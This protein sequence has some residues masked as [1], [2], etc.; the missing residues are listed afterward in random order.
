MNWFKC[1]NDGNILINMHNILKILQNT[2]I[3][4]IK[5]NQVDILSAIQDVINKSSN[6]STNISQEQLNQILSA[7]QA[8]PSDTILNNQNNIISGLDTTKSDT[9]NAKS[10]L[11]NI[12]DTFEYAVSG[13]LTAGETSIT[14]KDD[15]IKEDTDLTVYTSQYS[16]TPISMSV[17]N[18]SV[19]LIFDK[20][21][22]DVEVKVTFKRDA[23][24]AR[25]LNNAIT[26]IDG[27]VQTAEKDIIFKFNKYIDEN[28]STLPYEFCEGLAVVYNNEIHIL[29]GTDGLTKHYKYDGSSWIEVS[30]L[31][32]EFSNSYGVVYNDEIH[33]MGG[34]NGLT[35]HYK[36]DDS[37]WSQVSTLPYSFKNGL[38]VVYNNEIH[39]MGGDSN[40]TKHYKYN[41]SSWTEVSTLP[42]DVI[43]SRAVVLNNEI[44]ILGGNENGTNNT[45]HYK[46]NGSTWSNVSTLPYNFKWGQAVVLNNE[47]HILGG[48]DSS[49][50][51]RT[52]H[53]IVAI[54]VYK[55]IQ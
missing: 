1:D 50:G 47:I 11:L 2:S 34:K 31:P 48:G 54:P 28:K 15:N 6:G 35:N 16:L 42:Y 26:T 44:H 7:V 37:S 39:I 3:P 24:W 17:T 43:R 19:T 45:K 41:G 30:T 36:W 40:T 52:K 55:R 4:D 14:L 10:T 21:T 25:V 22:K 13:T 27:I 5:Q 8:I 51:N 46:Y 32:Y 18:G 9:D 20:Q 49:S 33:I 12:Y 29:G 23:D 38:V 53:Y